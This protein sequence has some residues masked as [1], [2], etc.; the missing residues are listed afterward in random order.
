MKNYLVQR[1]L[2]LCTNLCSSI[3]SISPEEEKSSLISRAEAPGE[4]LLILIVLICRRKELKL[5]AD[6]SHL[7]Q[8]TLGGHHTMIQSISTNKQIPSSD[9]PFM[10]GPALS[11]LQH[12]LE[13]FTPYIHTPIQICTHNNTCNSIYEMHLIHFMSHMYDP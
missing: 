13:R 12:I 3:Y 9:A 10:Q 6:Y 8:L 7:S 5:S 1:K 11:Q 2:I 4:R